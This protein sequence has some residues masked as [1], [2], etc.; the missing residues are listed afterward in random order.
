MGVG[1]LLAFTGAGI[2]A[3]VA[4]VAVSSDLQH[5]LSLLAERIQSVLG[6]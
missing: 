6:L 2:A 3:I 4:A 1:P 5:F